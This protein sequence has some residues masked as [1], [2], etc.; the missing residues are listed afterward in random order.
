MNGSRGRHGASVIVALS[1]LGCVFVQL[2]APCH[3]FSPVSFSTNTN[4]PVL[5][6]RLFSNNA[7][8]S[9]SSNS[10]RCTVIC[11]SRKNRD[12]QLH[13]KRTNNKDEDSTEKKNRQHKRP[14]QP[15]SSFPNGA[16]NGSGPYVPSGLTKEE[17]AKIKRQEEEKASKMNYAMWGPRFRQSKAPTDDWMVM[18]SLWTG[19]FNSNNTHKNDNNN[20]GTLQSPPRIRAVVSFLKEMAPAYMIAYALTDVLLTGYTMWRVTS[21]TKKSM[22][23]VAV[24]M[25][26]WQRQQNVWVTFWKFRLVKT[27]CASL[28]VPPFQKFVTHA[29]RRWLWSP[30][31]TVLSSVGVL[32][33]VLGLWGMALT[34]LR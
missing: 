20:N 15:L 13:A 9:G 10:L 30:K 28:L 6:S 2:P 27:L 7:M 17:Y 11:S 12:S 26:L 32:S 4:T 3:S 21:M 19:G 18:P 29:N 34:T 5:H 33:G 23:T 25:M 1:L 31:R 24:R 8:R 22:A 16:I 14:S